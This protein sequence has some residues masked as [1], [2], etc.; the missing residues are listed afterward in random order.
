[1]DAAGEHTFQAYFDERRLDPDANDPIP[2]GIFLDHTDWFAEQKGL[3][4]E[5]ILVEALTASDGHFTATMSDGTF[6]TAE[7]V[8]AAPGSPTSPSV[9]S[10]TTSCRTRAGATPASW[11]P[12]TTWPAPGSP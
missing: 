7:R 9:R 2:V 3:D 4:V 11:W 1:L 5:E 12:S 6:L 10:G 8:V